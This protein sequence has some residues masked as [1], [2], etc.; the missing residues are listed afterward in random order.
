MARHWIGITLGIV[1]LSVQGVQGAD[2]P[3][4]LVHNGEGLKSNTYE[5]LVS[6]A[7]DMQSGTGGAYLSSS[8]RYQPNDDF[9]VGFGFGAGEPGYNF[10]LNGVWYVLPD[11]PNQPAFAI[12]GGV[13][14][15]RIAPANFFVV[16]AVPMVSKGFKMDW[17]KVT[18]YAGLHLTPSFRLGQPAN[19]FSMKTSLGSEFS[20]KSLN[21]LHLWAE[22]D[23]GVLE[24]PQE[25]VVGV[26]YPFNAL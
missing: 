17:G 4:G 15:N 9:G 21:N 3:G 24:S 8:I 6:P 5:L 23:V 26:S 14:M 10:G 22:V 7:Y 11:T 1:L 12:L 2:I 16:K 20:L 18:P 19:V 13:Y 25:V